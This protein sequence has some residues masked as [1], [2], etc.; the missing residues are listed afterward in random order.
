MV[1]NQVGYY[2]ALSISLAMQ[3]SDMKAALLKNIDEK[4]LYIINYTD[5][6]N[7]IHWEDG[8]NT[9]FSFNSKM[10]DVVKQKKIKGKVLLYCLNDKKEKQLLDDYIAATKN[11]GSN[12]KQKNDT[13]Q[14]VFVFAKANEESTQVNY[15]S[16]ALKEIVYV[17][18]LSQG[19]GGKIFSPPRSVI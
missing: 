15:P 4:Q 17:Q 5:S 12:K 14:V 16:S 10:Y 1:F 7:D 8:G 11:N 6:K 19:N 2:F 18:R 13:Q 9:E 3:R